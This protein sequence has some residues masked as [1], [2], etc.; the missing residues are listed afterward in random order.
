MLPGDVGNNV[1]VETIIYTNLNCVEEVENIADFVDKMDD[2]EN[3]ADENIEDAEKAE[4][5]TEDVE[6][7]KKIDMNDDEF[8]DVVNVV[9]NATVDVM[10]GAN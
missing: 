1:D 5:S 8:K 2:D 10:E 3:M 6:E 4:D 7:P 9:E